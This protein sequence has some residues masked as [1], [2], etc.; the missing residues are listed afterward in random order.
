MHFSEISFEKIELRINLKSIFDHFFS[1]LLI[2]LF[3]LGAMPSHFFQNHES[4]CQAL[5]KE[6]KFQLEATFK[7]FE[8]FFLKKKIEKNLFD[9]FHLIFLLFF[10]ILKLLDKY[11]HAW[12]NQ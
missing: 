3:F 2:F 12:N 4:I 9:Q 11:L 7:Y 10:Y 5:F 6:E 8:N 1:V